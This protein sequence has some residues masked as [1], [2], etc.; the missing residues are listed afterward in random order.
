MDA[1]GLWLSSGLRHCRH[2][3]PLLPLLLLAAPPWLQRSEA[4]AERRREGQRP[5]GTEARTKGSAPVSDADV[6]LPPRSSL[7]LRGQGRGQRLR[8]WGDA[9]G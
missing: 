9:D 4:E 8:P 3:M 6:L 2:V 5:T 1:S 7:C